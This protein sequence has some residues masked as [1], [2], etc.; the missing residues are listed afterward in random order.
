VWEKDEGEK[1]FNEVSEHLDGDKSCGKALSDDKHCGREL[2][3]V[4]GGIRRFGSMLTRELLEFQLFS[5]I[6]QSFD[7]SIDLRKDINDLPL[8][9][10]FKKIPKLLEKSR[11]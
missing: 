7:T 9:Q 6:L 1:S 5:M 8:P 4:T 2:V 10:I 3:A 11:L